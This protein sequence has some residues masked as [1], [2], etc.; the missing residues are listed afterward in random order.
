[1]V[2]NN[3]DIDNMSFSQ[4]NHLVRAMRKRENQLSR[5]T[6]QF[7]DSVNKHLEKMLRDTNSPTS[8]QECSEAARTLKRNFALML[9]LWKED[10]TNLVQLLTE[11][12]STLAKTMQR[13]AQLPNDSGK[14]LS[15]NAKSIITR[16]EKTL[17]SIT[18]RFENMEKTTL[19]TLL[20]KFVVRQNPELKKWFRQEHL[21][22]RRNTR[23]IVALAQERFWPK[24]SFYTPPELMVLFYI[25]ADILAC[26]KSSRINSDWL[27]CF[28]D[29][30]MEKHWEAK[31]RAQ[32]PTFRLGDADT[33]TWADCI[34]AYAGRLETWQ[35]VDYVSG[36]TTNK[37]P[38]E[39]DSHN[40]QSDVF[41]LEPRHFVPLKDSWEYFCYHQDVPM[42]HSGGPLTPS[43]LLQ[44]LYLD[45]GAAF[46]KYGGIE[47][48]L[49]PSIL[50]DEMLG[51]VE[52]HNYSLLSVKL[53]DRTIQVRLKNGQVVLFSRDDPHSQKFFLGA[54][55]EDYF[56]VGDALFARAKQGTGWTYS[57][58]EIGNQETVRVF[59]GSSKFSTPVT[60]GNGIIWWRI[61]RHL[62]PAFYDQSG[63]GTVYVP[64][65]TIK[66][67]QQPEPVS[68]DPQHSTKQ[69]GSQL[70]GSSWEWVSLAVNHNATRLGL[71]MSAA[72]GF[73][74]IV[75]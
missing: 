19:S 59:A 46:I 73:M 67:E 16:A 61:D 39:G 48:T 22:R 57:I 11:C 50:P 5:V 7:F 25:N 45:N 31:M 55:G 51:Y 33:Q 70:A 52:D 1:M 23:P 38:A 3:R 4:L 68:A 36:N 15:R 41:Q 37:T 29:P 42:F 34:L 43:E 28:Q 56:E 47:F 10:R 40:L 66:L 75:R 24:E 21:S 64:P 30:H 62:V 2:T 69:V 17:N 12:V 18:E 9:V 32:N 20:R 26:V 65:S 71:V 8:R 13:L 74:A 72:A 14:V 58:F 35:A 49:P 44:V 27:G 54:V 60:C 53:T 63:S 6:S